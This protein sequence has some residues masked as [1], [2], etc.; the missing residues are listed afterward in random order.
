M[1]SANPNSALTL[2]AWS[3]AILV[4]TIFLG[5]TLR[6]IYSSMKS[7]FRCSADFTISNIKEEIRNMQP[8]TR[9]LVRDSVLFYFPMF[10]ILVASVPIVAIYRSNLANVTAPYICSPISFC[11]GSILSMPIL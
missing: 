7:R 1:I 5:L 11:V 9:T 4:S 8:V 2:P 10:G 6:L 3:I